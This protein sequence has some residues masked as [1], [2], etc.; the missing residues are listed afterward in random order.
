MLCAASASL[1]ARISQSCCCR[2]QSIR[3]P[4]EH[5]S[6]HPPSFF[7]TNDIS[8]EI[9]EL[10]H[11]SLLLP[12][13]L[14]S[15]T[16]AAV[17]NSAKKQTSPGSCIPL[18]TSKSNA[19]VQSFTDNAAGHKFAVTQRAQGGQQVCREAVP[20]M[21]EVLMLWE[22]APCPPVMVA[23]QVK[24]RARWKRKKARKGRAGIP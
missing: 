19:E 4:D 5:P 2:S 8:L 6:T 9:G 1:R 3:T 14:S 11:F 20:G 12:S 7:S 15:P 10:P 23:P 13:P 18:P 17:T 21:A 22:P 24:S 16:H